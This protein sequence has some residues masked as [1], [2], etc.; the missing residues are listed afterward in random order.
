MVEHVLVSDLLERGLGPWWVGG[1][2]AL[3]CLLQDTREGAGS[4]LG[5]N[6]GRGARGSWLALH[7]SDLHLTALR[8]CGHRLEGCE[9]GRRVEEWRGE[10]RRVEGRGGNIVSFLA[11]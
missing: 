2:C 10:G 5:S 7:R 8:K 6:G 4:L 3:T 1:A 11:R 9:G